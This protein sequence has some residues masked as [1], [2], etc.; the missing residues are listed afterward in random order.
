[1]WV[2]DPT[3]LEPRFDRNY[4]RHSVLPAV[5]ARWPRAARTVGQASILTAETVQLAAV[6]AESDLARVREGLTLPIAALGALPEA[7]QRAV[8]RAWLAGQDLPLPSVG[9]L[10]ALRR[11]LW[12]AADD[13]V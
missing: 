8:L 5:R 3:N 4:L 13:R 12:R 11:D 6:L 10:L 9:A 7:R 2:E 1:H